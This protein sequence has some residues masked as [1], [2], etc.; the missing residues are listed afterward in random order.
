MTTAAP[1]PPAPEIAGLSLARKFSVFCRDIK[2]SHT[3]FALPFALLSAFL[4]AG[5][6]PAAGKIGLIVLCMVTARSVAMAA[7]RLLDARLDAVNTRTARRALPAGALSRRFFIGVAM[8]CG[9]AFA[10]SC[11][12]FEYFYANPWPLRLADSGA[13][14]SLRVSAAEAFY[15]AV[16]LLPGNGAGL[17]PVCAWIAVRGQL[18][19]PPLWMAAAV[20]CWTAGFDIVYSC[21]DY[22]S[23][24]ATGTFSVPA[25]VGIG[26][27][28][29]IARFTHVLCIAAFVGLWVAAPR[30][31][32]PYLAGVAAAG[33][34]LIVEH[35]I[36]SARD[37]SRVNLA[38][39]TVNGIISLLLGSLG[40]AGLLL[41]R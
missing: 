37:L 38:F 41:S 20:I 27:A 36:V 24:L 2:I 1:P 8:G 15:P 12:G 17:A 31:G 40:I 26:N 16:S 23:D 9:F 32:I 19:S 39:F 3:V 22:D 4:A 6:V 35:S 11:A 13:R 34:L 5:G 14:H 29:W 7:N 10:V 25:A 18:A 28:L 33:V 21:Q 30:L